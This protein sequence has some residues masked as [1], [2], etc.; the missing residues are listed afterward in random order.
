MSELS[1]E[2]I[3]RAPV[4]DGSIE[5]RLDEKGGVDEIVGFGVICHIERLSNGTWFVNLTRPDQTGEAFWLAGKGSVEVC[6]TEHRTAPTA[7]P[8]AAPWTLADAL[9]QPALERAR[10]EERERL[11][12]WHD[13]EAK[14]WNAVLWDRR[15]W[16]GPTMGAEECIHAEKLHK[17]TAAAI[18]KG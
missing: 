6:H 8:N 2:E 17:D 3:A 13:N 9:L 12:V 5:V 15:S 18:R 4:Y 16:G 1:E 10:R 7:G 11:A 14:R